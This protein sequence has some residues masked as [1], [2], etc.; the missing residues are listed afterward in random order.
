MKRTRSI[1]RR[2]KSAVSRTRLWWTRELED[3]IILLSWGILAVGILVVAALYIAEP[4]WRKDF[5]PGVF[6]EFNGM[7]FDVLVFGIFVAWFMR[8]LERRQERQ[9]QQEIID[10][11][12]KW[13]TEEGKLR[14]SGAVRRINRLGTTSIDFAGIEI[15]DFSFPQHDIASIKGSTFY[16]GD[17]GTG[18]RDSMKLERVDF[19]FVD[20]REV[21]FSKFNPFTG[22]GTGLVSAEL[23]DC[24]FNYADLSGAVFRGAHLEWTTEHPD[25][26]GVWHDDDEPPSFEQTYYPPFFNAD[27]EGALFVDATFK[28]AD[29][30]GA[31]NVLDCDFAGAKGLETCIFDDEDTKNAVLEMS[32][33][34]T[35]R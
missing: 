13:D 6:V 26:L 22:F 7:L 20:C 1:N 33:R 9:R 32:K 24:N 34:A 18:S 5:L 8:R 17:W 16:D 11:Y 4:S 23:K 27:L 21:I 2:I 30:R 31:N 25:E 19:G 10:D 3:P 28:N 14:I 35:S 15:S 12:K 29:F